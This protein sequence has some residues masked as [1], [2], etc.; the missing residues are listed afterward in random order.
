MVWHEVVWA[1]MM[2]L[3]SLAYGALN[4]VGTVDIVIFD[5]AGVK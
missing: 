1:F 2:L 4:F 5:W 3:K